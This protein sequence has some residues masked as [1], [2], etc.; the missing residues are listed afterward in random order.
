MDWTSK[1]DFAWACG[2]PDVLAGAATRLAIQSGWQIAERHSAT[3]WEALPNFAGS[4]AFLPAY[5]VDFG[6]A[7][8]LDSLPLGLPE[9]GQLE[10]DV[11]T[12]HH[13]D[14]YAG[15][16][17]TATDTEDPVPVVFPAVA[18]GHVFAFALKPLR[19]CVSQDVEY[20]RAW[21]ACGLSTFGLGAKTNAGYGWF[22]CG[23]EIDRVVTAELLALQQ[24]RQ[25]QIAREALEQRQ[26]REKEEQERQ[27]AERRAAT[28]NL[29][30]EQK[31]D[32]ELARLAPQQ[33]DSWL[34]TFATRDLPEQQAIVRALRLPPEAAD[35]RRAVWEKLKKKAEK[36]GKPAKVA[37]A[38]RG[39][40][41]QMLP[42]KE[43]KM[44]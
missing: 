36:G 9:P 5:P 26:K 27:A 1:S 15:G 25:D 4:V 14:Y 7:G 30:P 6:K 17:P 18:P 2:Q 22:A 29:T 13:T 28:A 42:G 32:W 19:R 16:R 23:S 37:E 41:K 3:P 24:R 8:P 12:C 11:V 21:L 43:G 10:L 31:I 44:P 38:I 39:L 20:A 34:E 40:S 33:F 35:S